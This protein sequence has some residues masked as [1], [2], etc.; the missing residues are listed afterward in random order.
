MYEHERFEDGRE[1]AE[2]D[3][4]IHQKAMENVKLIFVNS[5]QISI[6]KRDDDVGITIESCQHTSQYF[7]V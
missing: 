4:P 3:A 2:D 5:C 1:N 6:N 7:R